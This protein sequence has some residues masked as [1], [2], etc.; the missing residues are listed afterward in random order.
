VPAL[1]QFFVQ[2]VVLRLSLQHAASRPFLKAIRKGGRT[3]VGCLLLVSQFLGPPALS[4][5]TGSLECLDVG[6]L[7]TLKSFF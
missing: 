7:A 3:L 2:F 6:V 1:N 4:L 5:V